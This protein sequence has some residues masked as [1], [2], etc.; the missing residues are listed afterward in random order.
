[1][2]T[3]G[4]SQWQTYLKC[5]RCVLI[6]H[7]GFLMKGAIKGMW[8]NNYCF[9]RPVIHM[10]NASV[11]YRQGRLAP[12]L[13]F[14][15]EREVDSRAL[16]NLPESQ[17]SDLS[18]MI[19]HFIINSVILTNAILGKWQICILSFWI[20]YEFATLSL[21][22]YVYILIIYNKSTKKLNNL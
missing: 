22:N 15:F 21:W 1:M 18:N 11:L 13:F 10:C 2:N 14:C 7:G 17:W 19:T 16:L 4:L 12:H 20:L 3:L 5:G 6:K 9:F 8:L